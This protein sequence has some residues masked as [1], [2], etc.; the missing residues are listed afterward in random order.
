ML[1]LLISTIVFFIAAWYFNRY[2]DEQEI[3]KGMTRGVLVFVLASLLSWGSGAVLDWIQ[4]K[5]DG[6]QT[7]AQPSG[8]LSQLLNA[9]RQ[10]Q[11]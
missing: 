6:P 8:D 10:A 5:M 1:N 7:T 4:V 11:P 3:A 9:A 2:L